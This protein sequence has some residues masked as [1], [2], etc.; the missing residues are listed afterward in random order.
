MSSLGKVKGAEWGACGWAA[1]L[2]PPWRCSRPLVTWAVASSSHRQGKADAPV[3][4]ESHTTPTGPQAGCCPYAQ[5]SDKTL[6]LGETLSQTVAPVP[7]ELYSSY[8]S[9]QL[10]CHRASVSINTLLYV[11]VN[12]ENSCATVV[13]TRDRFPRTRV[14]ALSHFCSLCT[15]PRPAVRRAWCLNTRFEINHGNPVV[16]K[17]MKRNAGHHSSWSMGTGSSSEV[18][19]LRAA[20][21]APVTSQC[22]LRCACRR[23]QRRSACIPDPCP[24]C[25]TGPGC[26]AVSVEAEPGAQA[27]GAW[28]RKPMA[29]GRY[30]FHTVITIGEDEATAAGSC[31]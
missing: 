3:F 12:L 22:Y 14:V 28:R 30:Y 19:G 5:R 9:S 23:G 17:T 21:S 7:A 4:R 31:F 6:L 25:E 15:W 24:H 8:V 1:L 29:Y 20:F 10:T 13:P 2:G 11:D 27:P 16:I 18:S 26:C